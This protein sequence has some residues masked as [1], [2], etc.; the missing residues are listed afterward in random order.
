MHE[1]YCAPRAQLGDLWA[2]GSHRLVCGDATDPAIVALVLGDH[3]PHLMVT[4][5]PYGVGYDP[6][7]R[8]RIVDAVTGRTKAGFALGAVLNDDQADWRRAWDLFPG[9]VA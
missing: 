6:A 5:P 3:V 9:D 1:I 7:W 8:G 4:D 2:L